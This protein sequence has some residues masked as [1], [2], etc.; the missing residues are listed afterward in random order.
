MQ[1]EQ[2]GNF[3]CT[4]SIN[5]G[6]GQWYQTDGHEQS[7]KKLNYDDLNNTTFE[8]MDISSIKFDFQTWGGNHTIKEIRLYY[9]EIS[10][11][12]IESK[13]PLPESIYPGDSINLNDYFTVKNSDGTELTGVTWSVKDNNG[14]IRENSYTAGGK[15]GTVTIEAE[16]DGVKGTVELTIKPIE[17]KVDSFSIREGDTSKI[18]LKENYSGTIT[19]QSDDT[20]VAIVDDSGNIAAVSKGTANITVCRN[21]VETECKITVNVVGDMTIVDNEGSPIPDNS[22]NVPIKNTVQLKTH[23]SAGSVT[24]ESSDPSVVS[25]D[26]NTGIITALDFGRSTI[27]ATDEQG[28]TAEITVT[29]PQQGILPDIPEGAEQV[30]GIIEL[31]AANNW[32]YSNSN[33]PQCDENGNRYCYYIVEVDPVTKQPTQRISGKN[34]IKYLPILYENNG[35][36]LTDDGITLSVTNKAVQSPG[37]MPS[38]G[39]TGIRVYYYFGG[40]MT[41]SAAS[42]LLYKRRRKRCAK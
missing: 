39:G 25:V 14:S 10:S 11:L 33:L 19:Y 30:G 21:D 18:E 3:G 28:G 35:S 40:I 38:T 17:V 27:K 32:T 31:N 22:L 41:L 24:W 23:D 34:N 2:N 9:E 7:E 37:G 5:N 1:Y 6:N 42:I 13:Q 29:V 36:P 8:P 16:K 26:K 12:T 20:A 4:I 15:S